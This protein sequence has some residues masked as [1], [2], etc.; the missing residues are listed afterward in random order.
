MKKDDFKKVFDSY[1]VK[2]SLP[3]YDEL[4][5]YFEL[6]NT[7]DLWK[8]NTPPFPLRQIRRRI[9]DL[10]NNMVGYLHN[11]ILPNTQ[12]AIL[13]R[14]SEFF[15]DKEKEE[16]V[17]L[18]NEIMALFRESHQLEIMLDEKK[19]AEFIKKS[20]KKYKEVQKK[21]SAILEKN[22]D[23]WN[24]SIDGLKKPKK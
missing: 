24:K 15:S 20:F 23:G 5:F 9:I 4:D 11:F 21:V 13:M 1:R 6:T 17:L 2:Y 3:E 22:I 16:I 10:F 18:I 7:I 8:D 19:D 14:E 12:S